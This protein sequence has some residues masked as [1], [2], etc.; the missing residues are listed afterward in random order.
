MLSNHDYP[1]SASGAH[2]PGWSWM[3][4]PY[5]STRS[6]CG[7]VQQEG[8]QDY[9]TAHSDLRAFVAENLV[10]NDQH[11]SRAA[12]AALRDVTAQEFVLVCSHVWAF[13]SFEVP[14]GGSRNR[15][16]SST[17]GGSVP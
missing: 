3:W 7:A 2:G 4:V 9:R 10:E 11:W 13:A 12:V 6:T 8:L 14:S 1:P 17:T 15:A 5:P 16:P